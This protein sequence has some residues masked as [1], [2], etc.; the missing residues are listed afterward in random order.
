MVDDVLAASPRLGTVRLLAVDGPSGAGKSTVAGAAAAELRSRGVEIALVPTDAFATWD[1][2]VS[3]WP[4]LAGG[5]LDPLA[6]GRVGRY[7]A[8]SWANGVPQPGEL[9]TVGVTEVLIVEGVSAGRASVQPLLSHLC[10]VAGP[11]R[12]ARLHRSVAR[13]GPAHR[14]NLGRWQAFEI[15]WFGVDRPDRRAHSWLHSSG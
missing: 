3:W 8:L 1:D 7:R 5:V 11:D 4:R 12:S 9:V 2:P 15:G 14:A 6:A 13:D 10:W